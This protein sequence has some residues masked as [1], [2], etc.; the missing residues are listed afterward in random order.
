MLNSRPENG[1]LVIYKYYL[2]DY[3]INQKDSW[4]GFVLLIYNCINYL[5]NKLNNFY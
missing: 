4:F 3:K 1:G 5:I 2:W